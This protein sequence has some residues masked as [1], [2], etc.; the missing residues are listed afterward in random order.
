MIIPNI[1]FKMRYSLWK[2]LDAAYGNDNSQ[3]F[4]EAAIELLVEQQCY[5][6]L[7]K[8]LGEPDKIKYW[9]DELEKERDITDD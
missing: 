8:K 6:R 1:Y 7:N 9:L 2:A 4:L 5:N 3:E